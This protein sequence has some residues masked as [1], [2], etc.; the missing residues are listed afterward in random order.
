MK[1]EGENER[2]FWPYQNLL[3]INKENIELFIETHWKQSSLQGFLQLS[4]N[5]EHPRA[6]RGIGGM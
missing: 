6:N 5:M 3:K 1:M 2:G 4:Q